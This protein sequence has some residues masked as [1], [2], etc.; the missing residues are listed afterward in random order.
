MGLCM[1]RCSSRRY[2]S[3]HIKHTKSDETIKILG[4]GAQSML[5][6]ATANGI[7]QHVWELDIPY[8]AKALKFFWV[9]ASIGLFAIAFAK[10]AIVALFLGIQGP[11]Q[12]KRRM[13]LHF[14]WIS[15]L[16]FSIVLVVFIFTQCTP[17]AKIWDITIIQG[18]CN[19]RRGAL[20]F[21]YFQGAWA[22]LTD[23]ILAVFPIFIAWDLQTSVRM[24]VGFCVLMSGGFVYVFKTLLPP[25]K[26]P[27]N[28]NVLTA[29]P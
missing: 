4:M 25:L 1:G 22:A 19:L 10:I 12:Y 7:G 17:V 28:T 6:V 14:L 26:Q 15:N 11:S 3:F 8:I 2:I 18:N 16:V 27:T 13:F 20:K 23:M 29:Q 24:K 5:T 21:G 9:S